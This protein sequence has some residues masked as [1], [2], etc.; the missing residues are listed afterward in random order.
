M[1]TDILARLRGLLANAKDARHCL[2]IP[3][4][5]SYQYEQDRKYRTQRGLEKVSAQELP[6]LLDLIESQ[7]ARIKEMEGQGWRP[8]KFDP[9]DAKRWWLAKMPESKFVAARLKGD[10]YVVISWKDDAESGDYSIPWIGMVRDL[11][12]LPPAPEVGA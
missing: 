12:A 5:P 10:G 4:D 2:S 7:A 6:A 8:I 11:I 1:T 9:R 3:G